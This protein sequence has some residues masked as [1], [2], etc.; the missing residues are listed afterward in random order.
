MF[1]HVN[2]CIK[3]CN[4]NIANSLRNLRIRKGLIR[5]RQRLLVFTVAM[6][7]LRICRALQQIRIQ[8]IVRLRTRKYRTPARKSQMSRTQAAHR[9]NRYFQ[10]N[11]FTILAIPT[12]CAL[13]SVNNHIANIHLKTRFCGLMALWLTIRKIPCRKYC[14]G[15]T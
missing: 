15:T 1:L 5:I 9:G 10:I 14:C 11:R 7:F 2:R 4:R 8:F 13:C 6:F 3:T 12:T